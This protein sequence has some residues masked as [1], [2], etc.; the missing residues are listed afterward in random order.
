VLGGPTV[1]PIS[2]NK[3][4]CMYPGPAGETLTL[5]SEPAP[6]LLPG[7]GTEPAVKVTVGGVT[8]NYLAPS[9]LTGPGGTP[10]NPDEG[11]L[12][13]VH[14]GYFV[15]ITIGHGTAP[16]SQAEQVM[17]FVVPRL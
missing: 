17:A 8:G 13:F 2:T 11:I 6:A 15:N 7:N 4:L 3:K 1:T 10:T 12:T 14:N 5:Q 16:E 9:S